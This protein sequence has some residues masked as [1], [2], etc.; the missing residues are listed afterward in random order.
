MVGSY[1]DRMSNG[2]FSKKGG[3]E[4]SNQDFGGAVLCVAVVIPIPE[5]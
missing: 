5:S 4:K 2:R 3:I 1:V